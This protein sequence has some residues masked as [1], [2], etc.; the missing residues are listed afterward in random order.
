ML[1]AGASRVAAA[2][3][4]AARAKGLAPRLCTR[5]WQGKQQPFD[6]NSPASASPDPAAPGR[7]LRHGAKSCQSLAEPKSR[8]FCQG[9][10]RARLG[11][12]PAAAFEAAPRLSQAGGL[13]LIEDSASKESRVEVGR[14][15]MLATCDE[16]TAHSP[17]LLFIVKPF[18]RAP[19]GTAPLQSTIIIAHDACNHHSIITISPP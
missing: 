2:A 14:K 1:R 3:R 16:P 15:K 17:S 13:Y 12:A 11:A 6:S 4:R 18:W 7:R 19:A 10:A 8:D 5:C 9:E